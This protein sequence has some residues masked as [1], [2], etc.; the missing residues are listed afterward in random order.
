MRL[1]VVLPFK[2]IF[3]TAKDRLVVPN[4][5]CPDFSVV[6]LKGETSDFSIETMIVHKKMKIHQ[7]SGDGIKA[8]NQ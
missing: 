7:E 2:R 1:Y 3:S 6:K 4:K 5:N 8:D